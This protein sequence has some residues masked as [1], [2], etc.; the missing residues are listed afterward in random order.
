MA[1]N[2]TEMTRALLED[3]VIKQS[4]QLRLMEQ[5]IISLNKTNRFLEHQVDAL[6]ENLLII[7]RQLRL[8]MNLIGDGDV[9]A[10]DES[11]A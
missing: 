11:G 5:Q 2:V 6:G 9:T 10:S 8:V 4:T 1:R 7:R 3:T